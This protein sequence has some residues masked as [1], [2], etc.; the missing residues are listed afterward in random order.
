MMRFAK[1]LQFLLIAVTL[2]VAQH[3]SAQKIWFGPPDQLPRGNGHVF[4]P[5]FLEL[6]KANSPWEHALSRVQVFM[7]T[8][9][10][11]FVA[12]E[13]DLRTVFAFLREHKIALGVG[14]EMVPNRQGCGY[15]VEGIT[16]SNGPAAVVQRIKRL[17][18]DLQ[19][20]DMDEPLMFGHEY[21]GQNACRYSI[22]EVATGVAEMARTVRAYYPNVQIG[23]AEPTDNFKGSDWLA[24]IETWLDAYERATGRQ[25]VF[26][27]QDAWWE[28]PWRE[29]TP[30]L[31][32]ALHRRGIK[33]GMIFN[34]AGN[35]PSDTLWI[36]E[37]QQHVKAYQ[38]LMKSPPDQAIFTSW[39]THPTHILPETAPMTLTYLVDWYARQ[40]R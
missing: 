5:D 22:K 32:A 38:A 21:T 3:A 33:Y 7:L 15:H 2:C 25:I 39:T 9:M 6:F 37:A 19:Y 28:G 12:S 20:I 10:F 35:P 36:N 17:G 14:M 23:E 13:S 27:Q 40:L 4:G 8:P 30:Q 26:F 11:P 24:R 18:G 16:L 1:R 29:R 34:A 31:I